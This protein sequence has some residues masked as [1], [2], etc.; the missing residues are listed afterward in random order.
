MQQITLGYQRPS[1]QLRIFIPKNPHN[2]FP[3]FLE[4]TC[5]TCAAIGSHNDRRWR[6]RDAKPAHLQC[7]KFVL[8]HWTPTNKQTTV[9]LEFKQGFEAFCNEEQ[10]E[11]FC[12][13]SQFGI[14]FE[15]QITDPHA[16][17][18]R[19]GIVTFPV[20]NRGTSFVWARLGT[21]G[22]TS[23]RERRASTSIVISQEPEP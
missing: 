2:E 9:S 18:S 19:D 5:I 12:G 6:S 7:I 8:I 3:E 23:P 11:T 15:A 1:T 4:S 10:G 17:L 13:C 20:E 14:P 21:V 22:S 16:P